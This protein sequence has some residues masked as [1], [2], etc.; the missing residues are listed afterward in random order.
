MC[1]YGLDYVS[2]LFLYL[3]FTLNPKPCLRGGGRGG[4][5]VGFWGLREPRVLHSPKPL[6]LN[7]TQR[8]TGLSN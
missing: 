6:A 3:S 2:E 4:P 7:P 1:V 5:G 8:I